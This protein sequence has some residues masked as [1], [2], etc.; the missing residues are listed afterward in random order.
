VLVL[1]SEPDD[2][3]ADD[4]VAVR[5]VEEACRGLAVAREVFGA[6]VAGEL[7]ET[8]G[9]LVFVVAES[10]GGVVSEGGFWIGFVPSASVARCV[11]PSE[12]C[13]GSADGGAGDDVVAE[14][15]ADAG[16]AWLGEPATLGDVAP[17]FSSV[18]GGVT[19]PDPGDSGPD[20]A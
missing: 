14:G 13:G 5:V 4:P 10:R 12:D 19:P 20:P 2:P 3:E 8:A 1:G 7:E 18:V 16:G 15:A 17:G 9:E 6:E 11:E